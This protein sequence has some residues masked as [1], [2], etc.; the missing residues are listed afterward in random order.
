[1]TASEQDFA[2]RD[3]LRWTMCSRDDCSRLVVYPAFCFWIPGTGN[4]YSF[5][6]VVL[7]LAKSTVVQL[8]IHFGLFRVSTPWSWDRIQTF[9]LDVWASFS[10]ESLVSFSSY[11]E[12]TLWFHSDTLALNWTWG[13]CKSG[14][15]D[16]GKS[17]CVIA[18]SEPPWV[19][20]FFLHNP[21]RC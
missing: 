19:N 20:A 1:M 6:W 17:S 9:R 18:P 8:Q 13:C 7:L 15:I 5:F 14:S 3:V 21:S 4:K 2:S 10:M 16:A 12:T 11:F